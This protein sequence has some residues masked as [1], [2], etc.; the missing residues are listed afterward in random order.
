MP[1]QP[2]AVDIVFR[3]FKNALANWP[4]VLIRV[5]ELGLFAGI[6]FAAVVTTIVPVVVQAGFGNLKMGDFEA[7]AEAVSQ[8][9]AEHATLLGW[10][11]GVG[12]IALG[13]MLAI[14]SF[15]VA[16]STRIYMNGER[17]AARNEIRAFYKFDWDEFW[18]AA[19]DSWWRVFWVYN[20]GAAAA[21]LI[22]L[23]PAFLGCVLMIILPM[24]ALVIGILTAVFCCLLALIAFL[25]GALWIVRAVP[26]AVMRD[27]SAR[28]ALT[29]A[30]RA[31]RAKLGRHALVALLLAVI[32]IG[33]TSFAETFAGAMF[34]SDFITG[35]VQ[36]VCWS[37]S[38]AWA[39]AAFV[40]MVEET[41]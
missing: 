21:S 12:T 19:G 38:G 11:L 10:T 39:L 26:E 9:I 24:A 29:E 20:L 2:T 4:L 35:F 3:A 7:G 36:V 34:Y 18:D 28:A 27:L 16:G 1:P 5:V 17:A 23:V 32:S 15:I 30:W 33:G 41:R 22:V 8:F 14:H 25:V 6:T 13:L 37:L 31:I 40:E